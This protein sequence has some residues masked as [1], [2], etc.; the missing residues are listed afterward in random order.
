LAT[1]G[2][3]FGNENEANK[4]K[5]NT[6]S[7]NDPKIVPNL[8]W[9]TKIVSELQSNDE[10]M[11]NEM[12]QLTERVSQLESSTP[13]EEEDSNESK[14]RNKR[15]ITNT[16]FNARPCSNNKACEFDYGKETSVKPTIPTQCKDLLGI[17]HVL[18]GFYPI[19]TDGKIQLV[20]CNFDAPKV[21]GLSL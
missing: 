2:S 7:P 13:F 17:G 19:L 15:Q 12:A 14:P 11:K 8:Q 4:T 10:E 5:L 9:L 21:Q 18:N 6:S 3:G 20:F 1:L 16:T